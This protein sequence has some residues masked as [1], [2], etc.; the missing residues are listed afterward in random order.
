[1]HTGFWCGHVKRD[2]LED[3]GTDGKIIMQLTE[4][5]WYAVNRIHVA[6][7]RHSGGIL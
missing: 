7:G 2:H 5:E 6:H 4:I 1:M 3:L